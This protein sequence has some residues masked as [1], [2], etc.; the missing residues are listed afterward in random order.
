MYLSKFHFDHMFLGA[1]NKFMHNLQE[2][3]ST[4]L[5]RV[6]V[7]GTFKKDVLITN[8]FTEVIFLG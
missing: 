4:K 3:K 1:I 6:G 2:E 5:S 7:W 8:N